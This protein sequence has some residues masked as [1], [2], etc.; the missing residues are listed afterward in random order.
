MNR[1]STTA[2]D[3]KTLIE[4]W[5]NKPAKYSILK[6]FGCPTYYHI[7]EG[8]LEPRAMKGVFMSSEDEVK[9]FKIWSPS[10]RKVILSRDVIFV[11][12]YIAF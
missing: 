8:K 10:E 1:S 3:F 7:S 4:A 9:G 11:E 12:L 5:S 6:V 2:I